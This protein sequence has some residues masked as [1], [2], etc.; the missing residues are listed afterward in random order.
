VVN[1]EGF[2]APLK[3]KPLPMVPTIADLG[4]DAVELS[5]AF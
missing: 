3:Q 2:E 4:G 5:H 1:E